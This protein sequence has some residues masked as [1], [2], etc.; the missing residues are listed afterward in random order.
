MQTEATCVEAGIF[1][2][3]FMGFIKDMWSYQE[4]KL[5]RWMLLSILCAI[6]LKE[7]KRRDETQKGVTRQIT[8]E[9]CPYLL[10][11]AWLKQ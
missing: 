1:L 2:E 9:K 4:D 3:I 6:S 11:L 7:K 8:Y 10:F 5:E